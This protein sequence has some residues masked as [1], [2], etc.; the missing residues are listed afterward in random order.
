VTLIIQSFNEHCP[1]CNHHYRSTSDDNLLV[2]FDNSVLLNRFHLSHII[3]IIITFAIIFVFITTALI[4]TI[5][6]YCRL[7]KYYS[8]QMQQSNQKTA[9]TNRYDYRD[10]HRIDVNAYQSVD[11]D[12]HYDIPWQ[13]QQSLPDWLV[14]STQI[15]KRYLLTSN[16]HNQQLSPNN[17]TTLIDNLNVQH[18]DSGLESV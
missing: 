17:N 13:Q 7:K 10:N 3:I 14:K 11:N 18:D 12:I 15:N 6:A 2:D 8:I 16:Y 4:I 1:W 5:I 9:T